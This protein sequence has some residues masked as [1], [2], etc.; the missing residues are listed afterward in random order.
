MVTV[1]DFLRVEK[2]KLMPLRKFNVEVNE[3]LIQFG[4]F[5]IEN[6]AQRPS[7]VKIPARGKK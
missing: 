4:F 7:M 2:W 6:M 3:R 1:I 5:S